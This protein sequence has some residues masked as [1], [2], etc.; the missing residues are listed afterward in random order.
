MA[1]RIVSTGAR[2]VLAASTTSMTMRTATRNFHAT[3]R[4][5]TDATAALPVRKPVGAFRGGLFGF[6]LGTTLAGGGVYGY[7]LRDYKASNELLTEDIYA[8]QAAC[9]RLNAY[10]KELEDRMDA[11]ERKRK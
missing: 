8:L 6:L 3:S 2:S 11:A 7:T 5:L 4:N 9:Q 10:V 1:A